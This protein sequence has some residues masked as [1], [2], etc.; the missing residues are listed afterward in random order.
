MLSFKQK[1][2]VVLLSDFNARVGKLVDVDDG[3]GMFGEDT[4][5]EYGNSHC[6][7]R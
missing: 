1:E 6:S 5:N 7:M 2:R 4:C 3:I